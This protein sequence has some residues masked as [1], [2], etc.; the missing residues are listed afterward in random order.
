V[1]A[2][3]ERATRAIRSAIDRPGHM[4]M[5]ASELKRA[6]LASLNVNDAT[7]V[8]AILLSLQG[9]RRPLNQPF[10]PRQCCKDPILGVRTHLGGR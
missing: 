3:F 5:G 10:E 4:C 1:S 8:C 6:T 9:H 7:D 2:P